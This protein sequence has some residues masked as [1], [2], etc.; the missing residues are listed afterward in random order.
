M[1]YSDLLREHKIRRGRRS[2]SEITAALAGAR[3]RLRSAGIE[4]NGLDVRHNL[5][6]E[7]VR[8][9]AQ[10][11]MAAEGYRAAM[12]AGQHQVIFEFLARVDA[13]RW[14]REA[15]YFDKARLRRNVSEYQQFGLIS[16]KRTDDLIAAAEQFLAEVREWLAERGMIEEQGSSD[17]R[18]SDSTD[19]L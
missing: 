1:P 5:A 17:D 4:A 14:E 8:V 11:V 7:A 10:V 16:A 3:Q 18:S 13:G 9:L 6:Y 2:R 12:A 19:T 15:D